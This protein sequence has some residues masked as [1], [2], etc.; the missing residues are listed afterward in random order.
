MRKFLV[1]GFNTR[2]IVCSG[3]RAGYEMHAADDFDDVDL[4]RC[5]ESIV[6]L[7]NWRERLKSLHPDAVV[8]A[9]GFERV[10][11]RGVKVLNNSHT[12]MK[13]VTNKVWLAEKLD[14]LG[15]PHPEVYD[16]RIKY[17]AIAKPVFGAGGYRNFLVESKKDLVSPNFRKDFFIQQFIRGRVASV[18]LISTR[19]E[20]KSVAVNESLSGR[21]ELGQQTRFGYCGNI[22][23]F[24]TKHSKKMC[25]IAERIIRDLHLIG[26]NG[27][28]F[29]LA[30]EGIYVIDV[31][32]RFQGS[33]DTVEAATGI[34][35]FDAH[36]NA[37]DGILIE[38]KTPK[39]FA[40][41]LIVFAEREVSVKKNL[42]KNGIADV[43]RVGK[44]I[45]KGDPIATAIGAGK[46]RKDAL[47]SA[48]E[49]VE[50]IKRGLI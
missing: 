35:L 36:V 13:K 42:D 11:V 22:T 38:A 34:N 44:A 46:Y 30:K 48:R 47:A 18:S 2:Y 4:C 12:T 32:P 31:N 20:V 5:A 49:K 37:F 39:K 1:V 8:L 29:I 41:R 16:S 28:D 43:P 10:R 26:S 15:I 17:P 27:I 40:A 19:E 7:E 50:H 3:A 14:S 21:R 24:V 33:L 45:K 23:P 9:S 6:P 25:E